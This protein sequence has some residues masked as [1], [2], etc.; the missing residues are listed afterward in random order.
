MIPGHSAILNKLILIAVFFAAASLKI[1]AATGTTYF[2]DSVKGNDSQSGKS[3]SEA[4]ATLQ[5]VNSETFQPGDRI[6]LKAG[7]SW[8]GTLSPKGSGSE[9]LPIILGNYGE[10]AKPLIKGD[11]AAQALLLSDVS[12]WTVQNIAITN[13]G[14][15]TGERNG[16]LLHVAFKGLS[17]GIH[18]LGVEVSDVN[19]DVGSKSSGGIGVMAWGKNGHGA[20]FDDLLISG[21]RVEHVDGQGIWFHVKGSRDDDDEDNGH[22]YPNTRIR[23]TGTTITDT[24]RNAIFLRDSLNASIDHNVVKY[25]SARTHGNAIVVAGTK[26]TTIRNNEVAF[27]GG[28]G[29]GE[30]GAFDADD[31]AIDTLIEYNWTHDNLGGSVNVVNDPRKHTINSGTVVR[32]NISENEKNSVYG[33]GGAIQNTSIYNN[34]IFIGK[35]HSP[36]ILQAGRFVSHVPGDPDGIVFANN[37]I[38]SEGGGDYPIS[39]TRVLVDSNCYLGSKS[40]VFKQDQHKVIDSLPPEFA[41]SSARDRSELDRYRLSENSSC[42]R[43]EMLRFPN[44]ESQNVLEDANPRPSKGALGTK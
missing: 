10:G 8:S 44:T 2:V 13:H 7:D 21:C 27:T 19:G 26:G 24:G 17:V 12:Y 31:G 41:A 6:L 42:S 11:G 9:T 14:P 18:L 16:V 32:Y 43:S 37:V 28:S 39:A 20:R 29:G 1:V 22:D 5:K 33:I 23:I 35:G 36:K 38:Y 40:A 30:N 4:W 25:A 3:E 15:H 34:T